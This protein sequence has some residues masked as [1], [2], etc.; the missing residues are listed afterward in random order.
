MK[1]KLLAIVLVLAL[2]FSL[3]VPAFAAGF[4]DLDGHWSKEYMQ[5]LADRGY[6]SGYGDGTMRPDND[7]TACESLVLLSRFYNPGTE[8][9]ALIAD[10]YGDYVAETVP[11]SLSWAYDELEICLAAGIVTKDELASMDLSAAIEK[12][13]LSVFLVRAMQLESKAESFSRTALTFDDADDI[14][15]ACVGSVAELVSL[16]IVTGDDENNFTPKLSVTRAVVATMVSRALDYLETAGTTLV[17]ANYDGVTRTEGIVTSAAA[18]S[19]T[20][21][22]LDGLMRVY[23]VA[24]SSSVTVNGVARS[25]TS[26]YTGC[27]ITVTAKDGTVTTA[28]ITSDS[29]V[30][31]AQ[32]LVGSVFSSTTLRYLY[33]TDSDSGTTVKYTL[34]TSAVITL[35]GK[36]VSLSAIIQNQFVTMK[37]ENDEVTA[38]TAVSADYEITGEISAITY[39]TTVSLDVKDTDGTVFCFYLGISDLP[40]IYRGTTAVT[41]DRLSVGEAVTVTVKNCD[42][43]S[44]V[45]EGSEDTVTGKLISITTTTSGTQWV[46]GADDGTSSTYTVDVNAGVYS[47]TTPILLSDIQAGDTV[48]VVLYGSTITEIYLVTSVSSTTKVSGTVLAVNTSAKTVTILTPANK[49]V[50]IDMSSVGSIITASTGK[51]LTIYSIG[52]NSEL[53]AYGTYSSSTNFAAKSIVIES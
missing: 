26:A 38:I 29:A 39:G 19:L 4:S 15:E 12:E 23:S 44:I 27:D 25:L 20:V 10:D 36:S 51:T 7:I 52:V 48:S 34:S 16:K 32:G 9:T 33:V 37:I 22:G 30:T 11:G 13:Q 1:N 6:L 35:D 8:A 17:I 40:A 41:I 21:R 45:T 5:D 3:S 46:V 2:A 14:S 24:P 43:S 31:W 42:V 18:G 47:G 50:Y 53:V 28:A 49:L